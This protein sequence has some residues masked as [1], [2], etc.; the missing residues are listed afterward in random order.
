MERKRITEEMSTI[1]E[2]KTN[3][4]NVILIVKFSKKKRNF[5]RKHN[6]YEKP[7]SSN[8]WVQNFN[9]PEI[10]VPVSINL[11]FIKT[12]F[13]ISLCL[14]TLLIIMSSLL[15]YTLSYMGIFIQPRQINMA[16]FFWYLLKSDLS[17]EGYSKRVDKVP[18]KHGHV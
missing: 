2:D 12:S 1:N 6:F 14:G 9:R 4:I 3:S 11:F 10:N 7:S 5:A 13:V 8:A 18:E 15:E 17:S 16:V